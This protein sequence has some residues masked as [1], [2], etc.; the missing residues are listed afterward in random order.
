[1]QLKIS[2]EI[3]ECQLK[4]TFKIRHKIKTKIENNRK[5]IEKNKEN[6]EIHKMR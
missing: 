1:M 4:F 3:K 2:I 5:I 6:N